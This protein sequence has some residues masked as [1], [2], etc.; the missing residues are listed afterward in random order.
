MQK[1][2]WNPTV[3]DQPLTGQIAYL[4][5]DSQSP[6]VEVQVVAYTSY[7]TVLVTPTDA[8][9]TYDVKVEQLISR[10]EAAQK[11]TQETIANRAQA[12]ARAHDVLV[13]THGKQ[14]PMMAHFWV[15]IAKELPADMFEV[16]THGKE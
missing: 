7:G 5:K 10:K 3:N 2:F 1:E 14:S 13:S 16:A 9:I 11:N 8:Q 12:I 6:V 15:S 4:E